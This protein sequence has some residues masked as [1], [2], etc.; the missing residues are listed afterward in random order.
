MRMKE[1]S[2]CIL[3][4][5]NWKILIWVSLVQGWGLIGLKIKI[6]SMQKSRFQFFQSEKSLI[7]NQ[8]FGFYKTYKQVFKVSGLGFKIL[9]FNSGLG[10]RLGYSHRIL[11]KVLPETVLNY[12]RRQMVSVEARDLNKLK[13]LAFLFKMLIRPSAYKKKGVFLRGEI[14]VLK[15][16]NKKSKF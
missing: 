7:D 16:S 8:L 9:N 14:R 13:E 1:L 4:K 2:L 10:F 11:Y 6:R 3:E 15:V 12:S 5:K